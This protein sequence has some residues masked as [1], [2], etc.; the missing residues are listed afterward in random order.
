MTKGIC[1]DALSPAF[2]GFVFVIREILGFR[3]SRSTPG[4]TL[5]PAFAGYE[6]VKMWVMTR[7][8]SAA[9]ISGLSNCVS[10]G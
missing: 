7:L 10:A 6:R 1:D 9:R 4:F 2:A 5:S 3:A 8:Y